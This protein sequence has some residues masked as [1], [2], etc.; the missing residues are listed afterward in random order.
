MGLF[1][2]VDLTPRLRIARLGLSTHMRP[3]P[4]LLCWEPPP[5]SL[6]HSVVEEPGRGTSNH[7]SRRCEEGTLREL[8]IFKCQDAIQVQ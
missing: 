5:P 7:V 3:D 1:A 6:P 8:P 4:E 2:D